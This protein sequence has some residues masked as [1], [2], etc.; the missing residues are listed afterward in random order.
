[1]V[2]IT[3]QTLVSNLLS[4]AHEESRDGQSVASALCTGLLEYDL[5]EKDKS[6]NSILLAS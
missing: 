4:D 3:M 6:S 2:L 1:M 5:W